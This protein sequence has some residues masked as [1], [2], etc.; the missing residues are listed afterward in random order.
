MFGDLIQSY[1]YPRFLYTGKNLV[2]ER[3]ERRCIGVQCSFFTSSCGEVATFEAEIK[4]IDNALLETT[5]NF[6][7]K[8]LHTI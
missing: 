7:L 4:F 3:E 5:T 6:P 1:E 8:I 2:G